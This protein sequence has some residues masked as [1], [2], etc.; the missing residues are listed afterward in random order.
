MLP[1]IHSL[2][3]LEVLILQ[4][5]QDRPCLQVEQADMQTGAQL[6][7]HMLGPCDTK[8]FFG[9]I[10]EKQALHV[11]RKNCPEIFHSW[12]SKA[13]L[14]DLLAK[15]EMKYQLNVDVTQYDGQVTHGT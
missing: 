11:R 15:G 6:L 14:E 8:F 4:Y 13:L 10:W 1:H 12:F 2:W 5:L 3:T 7:Q 9:E